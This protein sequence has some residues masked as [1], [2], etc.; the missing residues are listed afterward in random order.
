M[1]LKSNACR[2]AVG[3]LFS[4][5]G[6]AS[7]AATVTATATNTSVTSFTIEFDDVN[8]DGLLQISEI[9]S[10]SGV[11]DVRFLGPR[12]VSQS[13]SIVKQLPAID[14][15]TGPVTNACAL[16][17]SPARWCFSDS[18]F[19]FIETARSWTYTTTASPPAAVPLP[20]TLSLL[21][22]AGVALGAMRLRDALDGIAKS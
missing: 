4:C 18:S 5:F 15:I 22:L 21:G 7:H 6:F 8:G 10:F 20:A 1:P 16:S 3:L 11:E 9:T 12:R 13:Y 19:N 2:L 14:G 17:A